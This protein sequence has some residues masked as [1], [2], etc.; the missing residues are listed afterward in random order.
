MLR[1]IAKRYSSGSRGK[2]ALLLRQVISLRPEDRVLDLGGGDGS[3]LHGIFPEHSNVTIADINAS[4]LDAAKNKFSYSTVRLHENFSR[5]PFE[6]NEFD[7]VFCSSVIE[8]VTGPKASIAWTRDG[9]LF[10]ESA[11]KHQKWFA[12]EIRRIAKCYF[13]QTPYRYFLIES[14]TWLPGLIV[15]L[16]RPWLVSLIRF[17]NTFWP[18]KTSPD[19]RLLTVTEFRELF[20]GC[21]I[22]LEK[23]FAL[24]KSMMAIKS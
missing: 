23:S 6:D 8:H 18:K 21:D 15:F 13:V 9:R 10:E 17:T 4:E 22:K 3:H 12:N 14:H 16:P 11:N 20:A 2:R 19:W 5:L 24:T 1:K 7:L